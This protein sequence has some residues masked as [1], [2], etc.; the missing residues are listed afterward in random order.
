MDL[1]YSLSRPQSPP[2]TQPSLEIFLVSQPQLSSLTSVTSKE[3]S[4][5]SQRSPLTKAI[6]SGAMM[7]KVIDEEKGES[8]R[9]R[10]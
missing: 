2:L 10:E 8:E 7:L 6:E 5:G 9:S 4:V 3:R 1:S